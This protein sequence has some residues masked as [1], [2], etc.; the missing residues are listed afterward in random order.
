MSPADDAWGRNRLVECERCG[1]PFDASDASVEAWE[2][3][4]MFVCPE[5]ATEKLGE[6]GEEI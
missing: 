6:L 4:D 3:L 2:V 1:V 5:C